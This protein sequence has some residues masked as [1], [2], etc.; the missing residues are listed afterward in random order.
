MKKQKNDDKKNP[1][2]SKVDEQL[3]DEELRAILGGSGSYRFKG[4]LLGGM[5]N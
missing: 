3:T 2:E 5:P 1:I 4:P